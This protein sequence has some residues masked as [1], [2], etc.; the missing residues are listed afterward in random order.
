MGAGWSTAFLL[1]E[2]NQKARGEGMFRSNQTQDDIVGRWKENSEM[3]HLDS[4][5]KVVL[6]FGLRNF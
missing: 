6:R 1:S 3:C 5:Q 4:Q 2:L